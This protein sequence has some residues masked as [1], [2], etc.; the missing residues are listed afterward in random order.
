VDDT[1]KCPVPVGRRHAYP[2]TMNCLQCPDYIPSICDSARPRLCAAPVCDVRN[3][4]R[5]VDVGALFTTYHTR[6]VAWVC[7]T[8][9]SYDAARD[10]AQDVFIKVLTRIDSFRAS[11]RFSTWLYV[12]TRNCCRDYVKARAARPREVG[13]AVLQTAPPRV[14]NDAI[15]RLEAVE[16]AK[17]I[18]ALFRE[19]HL[20][21]LEARAMKLHYAKDLPLPIVTSILELKNRS[22]AKAQVV[23]AKRKLRAAA[24]RWTIAR[25]RVRCRSGLRA[26]TARA[27][28]AQ[29]TN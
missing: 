29:S 14:E 8:I 2:S 6:V 24:A 3:S 5:R 21:A 26:G 10:I 20:D 16:N 11:A 25:A 4:K 19:A 12:V 18:R 23:S 22:G 1:G 7:R 13:D 9:G 28:S 15:A 17:I 27:T